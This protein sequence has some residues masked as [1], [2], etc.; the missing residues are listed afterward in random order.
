MGW[1]MVGNIR[2]PAGAK[3]DKGDP[4]PVGPAG[5][6]WKGEWTPGTTYNKD[7]AVAWGG[8]SYFA[9]MARSQS[10]DPPTGSPSNPGED[11]TALNTGWG[12]LAHQ[13][14]QGPRGPEGEQGPKGDAGTP[15]NPGQAGDRGSLWY[16][17]DGAPG[18]VAGA[19][20]QDK[21]LDRSTGD[22]YT[23]S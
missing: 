13:G 4:G 14:A 12:L 21:Y 22:V 6:L 3:G 18:N 17:G 15:G 20:P 9:T 5:L 2:G 1:A 23:F 11:D 16:E 8:S 19:Q 10:D 7:D